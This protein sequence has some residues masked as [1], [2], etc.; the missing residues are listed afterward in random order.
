[1]A[2]TG[3]PLIDGVQIAA[4]NTT[5]YTATNVRARIDKATVCNTTAGA[6]TFSFFIVP[7]GGSS[8][9]TNQVID[10]KSVGVDETYTC[11]EVVG[12]WLEPGDFIVAVASAA[13][14]LT[15]MASGIEV[16]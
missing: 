11:P 14:S 4:S 7:F 8:G 12:H 15:L 2:V 6:V 1:M 10:T 5:Y 16:T 13:T 9:V 3:K